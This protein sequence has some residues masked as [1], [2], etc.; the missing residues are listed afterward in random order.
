MNLYNRTSNFYCEVK[1]CFKKM[2]VFK[3]KY[4]SVK[5]PLASHTPVSPS[6]LHSPKRKYL[7]NEKHSPLRFPDKKDK[8]AYV[9]LKRERAEIIR[10]Q[11]VYVERR[12]ERTCA[13]LKGRGQ[14]GFIQL[15]TTGNNYLFNPA[16]A[17]GHGP[18]ARAGCPPLGPFKARL[19][20]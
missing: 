20:G 15:F 3:Q 17:A 16:D 7:I 11:F 4:S 2:E 13:S 19:A 14:K 12:Y 5:Q 6:V 8:T 9:A 18:R 1:R 10:E